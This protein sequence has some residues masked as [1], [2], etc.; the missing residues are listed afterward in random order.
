MGELVRPRRRDERQRRLSCWSEREEGQFLPTEFEN[1][2][3]ADLRTILMTSADT[4]SIADLNCLWNSDLL[5][6]QTGLL[7]DYYAPGAA[8]PQ[9]LVNR[10][11]EQNRESVDRLETAS[12]ITLGNYFALNNVEA[13]SSVSWGFWNVLSGAT[14]ANSVSGRA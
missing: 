3:A 10:N 6:S 5:Y 4:V 11:Q 12:G 8:T 1:T 2:L 7:H 13:N 9:H 14:M